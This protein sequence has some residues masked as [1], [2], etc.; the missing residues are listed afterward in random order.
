[1]L[2]KVTRTRLVQARANNGAAT[3]AT[4]VDPLDEFKKRRDEVVQR[5]RREPA[6][7]RSFLTL[8]N[9]L[10]SVAQE[11]CRQILERE[12]NRLESDDRSVAPSKLRYHKET[13]RI[14]KKTPAQ[15]ATRFGAITLRSF[16]YM[17]EADGEPGLHPLWLR[18]GIGPGSATPALLERLARMSVDHTQS[19]VRAWLQREHGLKWSNERLRKA[20]AGFRRALLPFVPEL[21]KA[22]L[23]TWL[24]QAQASRGRHRPVLAA[25]RDGIMVPMRQGGYQEASTAGCSRSLIVIYAAIRRNERASACGLPVG[26]GCGNSRAARS[27]VKASS[28]IPLRWITRKSRITWPD[29]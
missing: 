23:L 3:P 10:H 24:G 6:T 2:L 4:P 12:A 25:G 7:P 1:M 26:Y 21:Q 29:S 5:F 15:I 11:A 16:Y 27:A 8:E 20:L 19:E 9:E 17:N 18:L 13:Y 22:R 28:Q 14:N